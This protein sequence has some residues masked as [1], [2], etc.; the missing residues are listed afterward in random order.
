MST[1]A[2]TS[3][4]VR[5]PAAGD[6]GFFNHMENWRGPASRYHKHAV[7]CRRDVVVLAAIL[8]RLR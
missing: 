2:A 8:D 4:W 7:V 1:S 6:R 5:S 3:A